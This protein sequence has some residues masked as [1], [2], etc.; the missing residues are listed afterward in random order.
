MVLS[1][2]SEVVQSMDVEVVPL[3]DVEFVLFVGPNFGPCSEWTEGSVG[4]A[5]QSKE[6]AH[7][8]NGL[9]TK[10]TIDE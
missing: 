8:L 4:R 2:Y 5:T 1:I 9:K 6:E 10:P 7:D 3:V